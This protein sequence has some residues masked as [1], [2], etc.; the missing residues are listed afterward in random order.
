MTTEETQRKLL[1][2]IRRDLEENE[3]DINQAVARYNALVVERRQLWKGYYEVKGSGLND[4]YNEKQ[5]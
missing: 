2:D 3:R 1:E 5:R 4:D